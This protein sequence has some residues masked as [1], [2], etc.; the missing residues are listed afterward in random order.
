[1]LI[2]HANKV[3]ENSNFPTYEDVFPSL[4]GK[5]MRFYGLINSQTVRET[6]KKSGVLLE[7]EK[8]PFVTPPHIL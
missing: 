5:S 1:M 7:T 3:C 2:D 4:A 6:I 8:R